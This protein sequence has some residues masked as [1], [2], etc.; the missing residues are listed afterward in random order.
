LE[1]RYW[2][3]ELEYE[4]AQLSAA[5]S[6]EH[7]ELAHIGG[8]DSPSLSNQRA[9]ASSPSKTS[10]ENSVRSGGPGPAHES[11]SLLRRSFS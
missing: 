8:K 9:A 2:V 1:Q 3:T 4:Q 7:E 5:A 6:F 10:A 11:N